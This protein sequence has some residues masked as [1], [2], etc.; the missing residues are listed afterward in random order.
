ML[1]DIEMLSLAGKLHPLLVHLPI[2]ILLAGFLL[3][4]LSRNG[5]NPAFRPALLPLYFT[6][7]IAAVLSC[8]SGYL[9]SLTDDYDA[10]TLSLHQWMGIGVAGISGMLF[11]GI[12]GLRWL[13]PFTNIIAILLFAGI[14]YTAH[15]GGTLT[16]GSNFLFAE[17]A[18]RENP[19][20]F[21]PLADAQEAVVYSDIIQP[22][23]QQK[24]YSC[25]GPQK[26]KAKLRLD[27]KENIL[28]GGKNGKVITADNH[29]VPEML[30]RI[31]LP[32]ADDDHMP[33]KE[34]GQ[35]SER[36]LILIKWWINSGADFTIKARDIPQADTIK[37]MLT[38]L[39][40]S[41]PEKSTQVLSIPDLPAAPKG[42]IDSLK[43]AGVMVLPVSGSMNALS[44]S[45][46]NL[47]HISDTIWTQIARLTA[48]IFYLDAS[49]KLIRNESLASIG[50]LTNLQKLSLANSLITNDSL[51]QLTALQELVTLNLT[52]TRTSEDGIARL[53]GLKKL[54][55]VYVF[56]SE[57]NRSKLQILQ[58]QVPG[59][60][61]DTGGY[62]L[63]VLASDT[64]ELKPKKS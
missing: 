10:A 40:G 28:K 2:G 3:H 38:S 54:K 29:E 4:W 59:V 50:K 52:G 60:I 56:G 9:L 15:L 45:M 11:L 41:T 23:L 37:K 18:I 21:K 58:V 19:D 46:L 7:F 63:P 5:K 6:G 30:K 13:S 43:T 49:G 33:P 51:S 27:G 20:D 61:I 8:L 32:P 39:Q 44:V 25:H 34:K 14:I 48:N 55:R 26:Q 53:K 31:L 62:T 47:T 42:I 24:C 1:T 36:Q 64:T 35:L 22:I 17:T 57:F 16:H 12:R